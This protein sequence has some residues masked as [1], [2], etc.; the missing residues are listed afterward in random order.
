MARI[1][2]QQAMR[3]F[4][5]GPRASEPASNAR[6]LMVAE[7]AKGSQP[8]A[9]SG[10]IG[11]R[12]AVIAYETYRE[13]ALSAKRRSREESAAS[14]DGMK[15][16]A[17]QPAA[18]AGPAPVMDERHRGV[19]SPRYNAEIAARQHRIR[20]VSVGFVERLTEFWA[21]HF[22][23]SILQGGEVGILAGPYEREVIRPHVLG[24]F[25]DMLLAVARHPAMLVYLDNARSI[26]PNSE[27]G[28]SG[29]RGLNENLAREILELHTVGVN[30]GYTQ[31]DVTSFARILTGWT[32]EKKHNA[33]AF[34]FRADW[35]EPGAQTVLGKSYPPAGAEQGVSVLRDLAGKPQTAQHVARKLAAA[36]VADDPPQA[37]VDKL[38]ATF[39]DT[40]GDLGKLARTLIDAEEAWAGPVVKFTTPQEFVWSSLRCLDVELEAG[41]I[42]KALRG[43]GN[44]PWASSSPAGYSYSTAT[45]L[46]PDSLTNRLELADHMT[47]LSRSDSP[48][49]LARRIIGPTLT[50]ATQD[51]MQAAASVPQAL[52]ILVMSAEFQRR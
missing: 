36:F 28:R 25:E 42:A 10:L 7:L 6:D 14:S 45:W 35:H 18:G 26:G 19:V 17:K 3:R 30:G 52:T 31:A 40:R 13:Q 41:F 23:I 11:T 49:M 43:L 2:D 48:L 21:N 4:G 12:D 50:K 34:T 39:V 1:D 24:R 47:K 5:Y 22:A 15:G 37:L 38:Q 16:P 46:A 29:G 51:A 8:I 32:F 9:D 27:V 33:G 44:Q 20:T